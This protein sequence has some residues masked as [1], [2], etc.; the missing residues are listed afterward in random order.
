MNHYKHYSFDLWMTLIRSNPSFKEK[1]AQYFHTHFNA[2]GKSLAEVTFIFRKVDLM[3]N[4]I[5]EKTGRNI[6]AS[7][8]YLMVILEINQMNPASIEQIDPQGLYLE[9]ETLLMQYPP[10]YYS[11]DTQSVLETLKQQQ[12]CTFNLLSNTGFIRGQ[13][14]RKILSDLSLAAFF[15]FQLYSDETGW[16]KPNPIFFQLMLSKVEQI[17]TS[18]TLTDIIHIGD[19]PVADIVGAQRVGINSLLINSNHLTIKNLLN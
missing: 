19:N 10:T 7:E 4:A 5:N 14:L 8:M 11:A 6:D 18:I 12:D 9:M 15:D 2:T 17:G 13:T 16:S 3:C 1:R